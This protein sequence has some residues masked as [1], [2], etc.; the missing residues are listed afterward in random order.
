MR[1]KKIVSVLLAAIVAS[2]GMQMACEMKVSAATNEE[3]QQAVER[4]ADAIIA[5]ENEVVI[6]Q[7]TGDESG[8]G[9][10]DI[11]NSKACQNL[12]EQAIEKVYEK[13]R[14]AIGVLGEKTPQKMTVQSGGS[15]KETTQTAYFEYSE[16]KETYE[17]E[18]KQLKNK[19]CSIASQI[20][21]QPEI[22][23]DYER[24]L[25][26][27]D[28]IIYKTQ[29][30]QQYNQAG[31]EKSAMAYGVFF[32]HRAIC[33]GYALAMNLLLAELGI[34]SIKVNSYL[35]N[36]GMGHSWNLVKVDHAWYH[37]DA[38][39]DDPVPDRGNCASYQFFLLNSDEIS[40]KYKPQH[41]G[42]DPLPYDAVSNQ[43]SNLSRKNSHS[44]LYSYRDNKWYIQE[45]VSVKCFTQE[46][47]AL[48]TYLR[49]GS[50]NSVDLGF[51]VT[52]IDENKPY[53]GIFESVCTEP[54]EPQGSSN[55]QD[56]IR[57]EE[58]GKTEIIETDDPNVYYR[59][60]ADGSVVRVIKKKNIKVQQRKMTIGKNEKVQ[61]YVLKK[62]KKWTSSNQKVVSVTSKGKIKGKKT[63]TA[64]VTATL[65]NGTN[66]TAK[67]IVKNAPKKI[68]AEKKN[69][70]IRK[71]KSA[72]IK[73][74]F[75]KNT[76]SYARIYHTKNAKIASVSGD[77]KVT[78]KKKGTTYITVST[79]N[80]KTVKVKVIV[81]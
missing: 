79:F 47:T 13:D 68:T 20:I 35:E 29:Y 23:S 59:V 50:I 77:G 45:N 27:H 12:F 72:K 11:R 4:L 41:Y 14:Y 2:Q 25:A 7:K 42:W 8:E 67:I 36:G 66:V 80:H 75:P 69:L 54:K 5:H 74:K 57:N 32:D 18:K 81:K 53:D 28:Y 24:V 9:V 30:D 31:H 63:G 26:V 48:G 39:W 16:S 15:R 19:V 58:K 49:L 73:V 78:A 60:N 51:Q 55:T 3:Y 52:Q 43:F 21:K 40:Q 17:E 65:E 56:V 37:L 22:D 44:Q 46:G 34:P 33:N 6:Y 61:L 38:T 71:K 1:T 64:I 70:T 76:A 62:I 10:V